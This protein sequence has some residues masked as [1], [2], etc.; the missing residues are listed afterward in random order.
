M[1]S[2][3]FFFLCIALYA[4]S[5]YGAEPQ[6]VKISGENL[7]IPVGEILLLNSKDPKE[8]E[9]VQIIS[10]TG[11]ARSVRSIAD[12][13]SVF[14]GDKITTGKQSASITLY[15]KSEID[16]GPSTTLHVTQL[17]KSPVFPKADIGVDQGIVYFK[18]A[19][20]PSD[21]RAFKVHTNSAAL[22]VKGTEFIVQTSSPSLTTVHTFEGSVAIAK[23]M[24]DFED[25]EK[26]EMVEPNHFSSA[27]LSTKKPAKPVKFSR[28]EYATHLLIEAPDLVPRIDALNESH[29]MS[30]WRKRAPRRNLGH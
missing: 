5:L 10:E 9:P 23:T 15:E 22:A 3:I 1:K 21:R 26:F 12:K 14:L 18:V 8:K 19:K 6:S 25:P 2:G 29:L 20:S 17:I 28:S 16:L 30:T 7:P 11:S 27:S 24:A 4:S 13:G